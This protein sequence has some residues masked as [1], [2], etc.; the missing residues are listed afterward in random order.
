MVAVEAVIFDWGG[1]LTPWRTVDYRLEWR[2][3]AEVAGA[4]GEVESLTARLLE[5]AQT[6]WNRARDEHT[7]ATF[8]EIC[9]AAGVVATDAHAAAYRAFWE[10]S[11]YTDPDVRPLWEALHDRDIKVGVLSNTIWP[12]SWHEEIFERDGVAHLVDGS[13]YTSEIPWTK[14][15]P[16][17]F[18]AAMESVGVTDPAGCVFVGDRIFDDIHGANVV[19]M[20]AV[21]VP[22]SDIP[23]AQIGHIRGTPDAVISRLADLLQV[24]APDGP[25]T[26]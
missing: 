2:T 9:A 24:L 17:A 14:P 11:T 21:F 10:P 5:S 1:T 4:P 13:V 26:A 15:D 6:V 16:R 18:L 3:V 25:S 20:R 22:H 23:D 19:G 8:E 12:R 7:S